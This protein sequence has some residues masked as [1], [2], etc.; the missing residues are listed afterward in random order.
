MLLVALGYL[1]GHSA[2]L[3]HEAEPG[4]R[5]HWPEIDVLDAIYYFDSQRLTAAGGTATGDAMLAWMAS[6][7]NEEL[8][9]RTSEA[10]AHGSIRPGSDRQRTRLAVDPVIGGMVRIMR[11][12]LAA[13]LPVTAIARRMDVSPKVLRSRCEKLLGETPALRYLGM[14]LDAGR[15][16]LGSTAMPVSEIAA[17][18]GFATLSGFSRSFKSRFGA[19]P[20]HFRK[21]SRSC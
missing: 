7:G 2:V 3:H 1:D 19:A 18:T 12:H 20:S 21:A 17:A 4:F 10:M 13:P 11:N 5:E 15:D 8:A 14:R 16:L 9:L 6:T